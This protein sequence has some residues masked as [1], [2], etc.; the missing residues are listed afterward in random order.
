[1]EITINHLTTPIKLAVVEEVSVEVT[2][3]KKE[4]GI[5]PLLTK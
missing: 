4:H 5:L 1:M 2:V 3:L